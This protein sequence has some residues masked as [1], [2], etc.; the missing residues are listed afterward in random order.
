MGQSSHDLALLRGEFGEWSITTR[1]VTAASGPDV[2]MYEARREGVTVSARDAAG[3][4]EKMLEHE[5]P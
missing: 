2:M 3:L 5:Q 1:W 4:R